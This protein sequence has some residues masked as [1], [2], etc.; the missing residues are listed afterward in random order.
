LASEEGLKLYISFG[1]PREAKDSVEV[2]DGIIYRIADNEV[3]GVTITGFNARALK[4]WAI[5]N[6]QL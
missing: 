2:E 6:S 3:M 5:L 1:R 4:K